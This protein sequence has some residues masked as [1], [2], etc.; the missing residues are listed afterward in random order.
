MRTRPPLVSPETGDWAA[1]LCDVPWPFLYSPQARSVSNPSCLVLMRPPALPECG[2]GLFKAEERKWFLSAL[3]NGLFPKLPAAQL[4]WSSKLWTS[5]SQTCPSQSSN[6]PQGL[7]QR[8]ASINLSPLS[9]YQTRKPLAQQ[10]PNTCDI[11]ATT[12]QPC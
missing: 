7:E 6:G 4:P 8:K 11:C 2:Q 10:S 5:N 12:S 1:V 3:D 9:R